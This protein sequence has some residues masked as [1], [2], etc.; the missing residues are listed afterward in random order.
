MAPGCK[1]RYLPIYLV[2]IHFSHPPPYYILKVVSY[3]MFLS[4]NSKFT[5][6][7][8]HIRLI[9][10]LVMLINSYHVFYALRF[11]EINVFY[12]FIIYLLL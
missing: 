5:I 12:Y 9:F 6:N 10:V 11:S 7:F 4:L 8:C 2:A 1:H 3:K